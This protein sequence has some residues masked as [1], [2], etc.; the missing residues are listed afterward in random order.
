MPRA[1]SCTQ[2]EAIPS[3]N[4]GLVENGLRAAVKGKDLRVL[5]DQKLNM[6]QQCVLIARKASHTLGYI[7]RIVVRRS[8]EVI[9]P[10]YSALVRS[11]LESCIQLWSP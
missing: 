5:V 11:H 8:R 10:L 3:T 4:T 9:L 6:T 7:K 2:V 1:R